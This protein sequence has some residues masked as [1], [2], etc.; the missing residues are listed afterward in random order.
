MIADERVERLE[1][2][3]ARAEVGHKAYY[4]TPVHRQP[5]M[6]GW[7]GQV[8]L[9]GTERAAANAPRDPDQP[10]ADARAGRGG[11]ERRAGRCALSD[12][13]PA[14]EQIMIADLAAPPARALP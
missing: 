12:L 5:P 6:R 9:P 14:L 8:E 2:A 10:G 7:A 3:L 1:A 13:A 11:A 4:R